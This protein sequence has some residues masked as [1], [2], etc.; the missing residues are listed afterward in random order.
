MTQSP[1]RPEG[2]RVDQF[3]ENRWK[4]SQEFNEVGLIAV[5]VRQAW[6]GA[7]QELHERVRKF[8]HRTVAMDVGERPQ[9]VRSMAQVQRIQGGHEIFDNVKRAK[10]PR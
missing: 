7:A 1:G 4:G 6:S 10:F 8:Q 5:R 2:V 3:F 9:S